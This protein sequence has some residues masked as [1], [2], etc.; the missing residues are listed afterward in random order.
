[1]KVI[2]PCAGRSSRF[3]GMRPKWMLTH[4]DGNLMVKKA[5]EGLKNIKTKDIIITILKEHEEQYK[6]IRGL[7]E[8]IGEDITI[9]I[10]D[11]PT[12]SQSE[13]VYLTLKKANVRESFFV[14][15]SDNTFEVDNLD[16]DFNYI[17]YSNLEDYEEI[18]AS[19]KSYLEMNKENIILKMVEKKIISTSFNVGGY[20]FRDVNKFMQY[21]KKLSV[22]SKN[23]K[24]LYLSYIVQDM[25]VNGKEI[26]LGKKVK[27]YHDWG[28]FKDWHKYKKKFKVYIFDLDGVFFKNSAQ[29]HEPRWDNIKIIGKNMIE[30]KKISDNPYFQIYFLTARPEKYRPLVE[31]KLRE[32]G[33]RYKGILMG[34]FHAK[35]IIVND[36]S[37]TTGY[38][39]CEAINVVRDSEN[40]SEYLNNDE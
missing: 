5:I 39:S 26:F 24:E 19:N 32:F 10:L 38:P 25:I 2:V 35:R 6:I 1:M 8:N 11:K 9:I 40:L 16:E 3:P 31:K 7:K 13:T 17:C 30:L 15:D 20:F 12:S 21:F 23:G 37:K 28:T 29:Y 18:N 33:I 14:K 22:L 34:C 4:P 27:G 36:F